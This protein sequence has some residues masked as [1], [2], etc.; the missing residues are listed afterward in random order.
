MPV[1]RS[2]GN[3]VFDNYYTTYQPK[4]IIIPRMVHNTNYTLDYKLLGIIIINN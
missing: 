2:I 3:L 4:D 1:L